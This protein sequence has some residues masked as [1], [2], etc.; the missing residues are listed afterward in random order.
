MDAFGRLGLLLGEDAI[1]KLAAS[2]VFICGVGGVGSWVAEMLARCA[3]GRIALMDMDTVKPS[4]IN[5][6][7]PALCS[8]VGRLKV[9]VMRERL[10][11]INPA[12]NVVAIPR[13]LAPEEAALVLQELSPDCVVDAI[14]ERLPKVALLKACLASGI[15][16]VSSMGAGGKMNPEMVRIAD[17]GKSYGCPLARL[18][19]KDLRKAGIE[20]GIQV[21]FSPEETPEGAVK[22]EAEEEGARR[23]VGT[24]SFM[25]AVFGMH[26]AYAAVNI[27]LK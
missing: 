20:K 18:I 22:G 5:R 11:D 12:A 17:I 14:D 19:R 1:G 25:P 15:P 21:V 27:L 13:R 8:T 16:V 23:P 24:I 7:L 26:C 9:E 4:N 6:Q 2:S 3:I 10:L